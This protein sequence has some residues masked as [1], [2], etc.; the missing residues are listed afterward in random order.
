MPPL[1][2]LKIWHCPKLKAL[3]DYVLKSTTLE[4]LQITDN[5]ILEEQFKAGG[6]SWPNASHTPTITFFLIPTDEVMCSPF[7]S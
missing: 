2:S 3:P 4:Q 5:P 6:K 1:C 7:T